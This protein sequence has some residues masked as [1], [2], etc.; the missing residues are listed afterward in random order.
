MAEAH[1]PDGDEVPEGVYVYWMY[2]SYGVQGRD[3]APSSLRIE[4]TLYYPHIG[5]DAHLSHKREQQ[6]LIGVDRRCPH[7][8]GPAAYVDRQPLLVIPCGQEHGLQDK[9]DASSRAYVHLNVID[10]FVSRFE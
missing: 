6:L 10:L 4:S 8:I 7:D 3:H 1:P 5:I 2:A 9:A